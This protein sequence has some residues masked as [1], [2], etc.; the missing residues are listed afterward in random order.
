MLGLGDGVLSMV[1][2]TSVIEFDVAQLQEDVTDLSQ[3]I[4]AP[5]TASSS[6]HTWHGEW[7]HANE[8]A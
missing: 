1:L 5:S 3:Q 4:D 2:D 8:L 6:P 7:D